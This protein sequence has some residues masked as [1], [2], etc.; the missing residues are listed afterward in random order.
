MGVANQLHISLHKDFVAQ[1]LRNPQVVYQL[2]SDVIP[3]HLFDRQGNLDVDRLKLFLQRQGKTIESL[4]A[5]I[6]DVMKRQLVLNLVKNAAVVSPADIT[7]FRLKNDAPKTFA[8]TTISYA[9]Y[10]KA[11][12][13]NQLPAEEVHA[14][15]TKHNTMSHR[16]WSPEKRSGTVWT[17]KQK[18][19]DVGSSK[20][21]K[22]F[23][24]RFTKEVQGLLTAPREALATFAQQKN[25]AHHQV[26][27]TV[28]N[29]AQE[30]Q[31]L[32]SLMQGRRNAYVQDGV[33]YIVELTAIEKSAALPFEKVKPEIL[34]DMY[35]EQ[36]RNK[37]SQILSKL[38]AG[39]IH[40]LGL[41]EGSLKTVT[42]KTF[43]GD[44]AQLAS[45]QK[46]G[47]ATDKM[48]RMFR[49]GQHFTGSSETMGYAV[50]L[51]QV[52]ASVG[53]GEE[54]TAMIA[55]LERENEGRITHDF[56]ASLREHATIVMNKSLLK[57]M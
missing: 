29:D 23:E 26:T 55:S 42:V 31:T 32:F 20:S 39:D 21:A 5:L 12:E 25:G 47:I 15:F 43:P 28:Q 7:E 51:S 9:P 57:G 44:D 45:L 38:S 4:D 18:G 14:Y 53:K 30:V 22:D 37:V 24:E 8:V 13:K 46:Q 48:K 6:E 17:F 1:S 19:Y 36:A 34:Q 41:V 35:Q 56:I 16:Y 49:Q 27:G 50:E 2:F 40:D 52:G 10:V 11:L 3:Y 54:T 33:G